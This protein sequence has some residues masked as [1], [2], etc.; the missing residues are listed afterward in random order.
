MLRVL[1]LTVLLLPAL[2]HAER[3][4]WLQNDL[5]QTQDLP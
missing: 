5:S 1:L 2:G 3:M 4:S